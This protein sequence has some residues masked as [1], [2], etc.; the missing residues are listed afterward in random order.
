LK[1]RAWF[2][3]KGGNFGKTDIKTAWRRKTVSAGSVGYQT[4]GFRQENGMITA[5]KC[6]PEASDW[7]IADV[8]LTVSKCSFSW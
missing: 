4:K 5:K 6:T 3:G 7:L 8:K 1:N 2:A